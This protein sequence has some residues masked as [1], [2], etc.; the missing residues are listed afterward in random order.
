MGNFILS[1][2]IRKEFESLKIHLKKMNQKKK[3]KLQRNLQFKC[4]YKRVLPKVQGKDNFYVIHL[5]Q[6]INTE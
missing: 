5:F 3:L 4:S 6:K 1:K 2:F